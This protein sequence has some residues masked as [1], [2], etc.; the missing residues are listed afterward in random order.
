MPGCLDEFMHRADRLDIPML[1]GHDP[2]DVLGRWLD[3]GLDDKGLVVE[4]ELREGVTLTGATGLSIGADKMAGVPL[5]V[6]RVGRQI[7]ELMPR[8]ISLG[9]CPRMQG[10]W[11]LGEIK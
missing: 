2:D 7:F 6:P 5:A 11:I 10:C 8:E 3:M 9:D 1:S 4:G